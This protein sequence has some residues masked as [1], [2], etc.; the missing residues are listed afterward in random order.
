MSDVCVVTGGGSGM[1]LS[2]ARQMPKDKIIIVS[3]RTMSK[4]EKAVEQLKEGGHEAYACTCDTSDRESVKKL[5]EFAASTD[6]GKLEEKEGGSMLAYA[7]EKRVGTPEELGF[8]IA[9][10]A[11][12]RNG[13]LAGVD[14]LV[15]G[16]S[17]NGKNFRK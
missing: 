17:T 9:T 4:L 2:A 11:D 12:E 15:D 14:V 7:A 16:G 10:V 8:A 5:V 13:Y 6:M 3:G 1:G